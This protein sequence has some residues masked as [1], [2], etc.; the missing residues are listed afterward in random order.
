MTSTMRDK[1]ALPRRQDIEAAD[2]LRAVS[3][4][5]GRYRSQTWA[6]SDYFSEGALI[7]HRIAVEIEYFL[8]LLPAIGVS[9]HMSEEDS[10]RSWLRGLGEDDLLAVKERERELNHDVKAVEYA[11]KEAVRRTLLA[12]HVQLVHFGLTSEDVNNL[13]YARMQAGAVKGPIWSALRIVLG[14]LIDL[15]R[16]H[17][18]TPML[19]RTHGQPATP[20]TLG[21]ELGVFLCRL[22]QEAQ[23]LPGVYLTGKLNGAT[24]TYGA[25]Q[26]AFPD[27]DWPGFSERFVADLGLAWNP[28]TTQ[29]EP[30]DSYAALYDRLRHIGNILIDLSQDMWRYIS[31][32][33]FRQRAIAGE[34]GSSAMPHKVNPIDFE[35]AEGNLGLASALFAHLSDKLTRSRL[36]RDLSDSTV[37]RSVGTA[38][39][40]LLLALKSLDR[41]LSRCEADVAALRRDLAAHPEVLAEAY[42]SVLRAAGHEAPYEAL[43]TLTRGRSVTLLELQDWLVRLDIAPDAKARLKALTPDSYVGLAPQVADT[44]LKAAEGLLSAYPPEETE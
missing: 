33:Y 5:D 22:A 30:H 42:Q 21:K 39:A 23:A 8:A 36:Q 34:V 28:V 1:A 7:Q 43:L 12:T 9:S 2:A 17:R 24:G 3:P 15:V 16:V 11:V 35:N 6:L 4:I 37:M 29:I 31:D 38:F 14:H 19:S 27:V 44:A 26:A 40:H 25:H 13:A 41:G 20:T 10:L 32:G 18:S